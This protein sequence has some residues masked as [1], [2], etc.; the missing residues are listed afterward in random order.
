[1]TSASVIHHLSL[2]GYVSTIAGI[3]TA[4]PALSSGLIEGYALISAQGLDLSKPKVKKTIAHAALNDLAIFAAIYQVI[5]KSRNVSFLPS[6]H[7]VVLSGLALAAVGYS[8]YLGGGLVYE[9]GVGVQRQGNGKNEKE[10][11]ER[12]LKINTKKEL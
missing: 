7:N 2:F 12:E 5:N 6:G 3:A 8:A 10:Q 11:G 9:H 1:M 4:L